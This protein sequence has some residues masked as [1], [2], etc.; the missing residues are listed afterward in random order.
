MLS[1][2]TPTIGGLVR[3]RAAA[4]AKR[5]LRS[6][7]RSGHALDVSQNFNA[8]A[9]APKLTAFLNGLHATSTAAGPVHYTAL[10]HS[11]GSLV[12]GTAAS[13]PGGIPVDDIVFVGSPGVSVDHASDLNILPGH[14][15]AGAAS[16]DPVP[17]LQTAWDKGAYTAPLGAPLANVFP[18]I[19]SLV[20]GGVDAYAGY[21]FV[22]NQNSI[23]THGGWF[24][25]N[26]VAS[27][28]GGSVFAVAPGDTGS[29]GMQS[30]GEYFDPHSRPPH[31]LSSGSSLNNMAHI[32]TGDYGDVH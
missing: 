6:R 10:G 7:E 25:Q 32:I 8:D 21:E 13:Q 9:G 11:Y 3:A 18:G 17:T 28:F 1:R 29:F 5:R 20:N 12:V 16:N 22:H 4:H 19:G 26:P 27:D 15:W 31:G 14:V 24:G 2:Q 30:H 23:D